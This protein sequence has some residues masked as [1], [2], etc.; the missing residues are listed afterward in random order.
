MKTF[1]T[2]TDAKYVKLQS[3]KALATTFVV[4]SL[5]AC[6]GFLIAWQTFVFFE[7]IVLISCGVTMF[8]KKRNNHDC[9]LRFDGDKLYIRNRTTAEIYEVF[10]IPA[11]DFIINQS[12][13][14][15]KLDYCSVLIKNTIFAF[16]GVKKCQE[17]KKY[18]ADNYK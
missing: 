10:D 5:L 13:K 8:L 2:E 6:L 12:K 7:V 3:D 11:S 9:V 17:L 15:E 16:G 1:V 18:I 4:L 14:E